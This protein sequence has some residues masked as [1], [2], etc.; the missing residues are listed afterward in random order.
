M[1]F[2]TSQN[3]GSNCKVEIDEICIKRV[4]TGETIVLNAHSEPSTA[5]E[6]FDCL[7]GNMDCS[8]MAGIFKN[9]CN[10]ERRPG[11]LKVER[12]A[13]SLILE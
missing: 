5:Q 7:T 4:A 3:A 9:D 2:K 6:L 1:R 13:G 8:L 10:N 11:N 12:D